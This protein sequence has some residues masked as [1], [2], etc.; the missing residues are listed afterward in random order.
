[1][2]RSRRLRSSTRLKKIGGSRVHDFL[3]S[4]LDNLMPDEVRLI[5]VALR[6]ARLWD[7]I[8]VEASGNI[9]ETNADL[10]AEAE[11]DVVSIGALTHSPRALDL[12]QRWRKRTRI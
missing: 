6:K 10:Y 2:A 11:A 3:L 7:A 5:I 12:S 4:M 8:L 9:T 1:M